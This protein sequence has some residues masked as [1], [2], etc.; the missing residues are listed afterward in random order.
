MNVYVKF[1]ASLRE[2]AG[3]DGMDVALPPSA[4]LCDLRAALARE[5]DATAAA[6]IDAGEVRVAVNQVIV[7]SLET[8]LSAGDE[9][10]FLPPVTGG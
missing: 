2:A 10:A 4:T 5:L 8:A 7:A 3:T 6:A 1:F 9:V